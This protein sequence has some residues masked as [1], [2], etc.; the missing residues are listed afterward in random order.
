MSLPLLQERDRAFMQ[1]QQLACPV[2]GSSTSFQLVDE[3]GNGQPYAGLAYQLID[4]EDII[5]SGT[6]DETGSG[7]VLNHYCGVLELRL[8]HAYR[9]KEAPY[10]RLINREHYPL[11]I[12]E[13]QVRAEHTRFINKNAER[14]SFNP[15]HVHA[16]PSA[17]YQVEVRELVEHVAHL[18]PLAPRTFAPLHHLTAL[19]RPLPVKGRIGYKPEL[20]KRFGIPLLPNKH[21]VLEV[22][23]LRALLP[24]MSTHHDFCALNLYQ[25][26]LMATLSYAPFGQDP[27]EHPVLSKTVTFPLQP[28]SG[29]WFGDALAKADE[30]WR[31]D[32]GQKNDLAHYP[33]YEDVAYSKRLEVLPFDPD[34]YPINAPELG[35]A[36]ETPALLHHLDDRHR[37]GSTDSQAF[38]THN[39]ERVLIAVRGTSELPWDL[40]T[41]IDARQV[42]F[43]EGTGQAHQGFYGAAKVA[44]DFATHY[45]DKFHNGQTLIITGHSL[46]GAIALLLAEML[47][48]RDGFVYDILLYTYGA[49]RAADQT[50]IDGA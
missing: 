30:I 26:A 34:L 15:A 4:Y 39:H 35:D 45:L 33:L 44:Y 13:L 50:F 1:D 11:P 32:A 18:P 31:V 8:N 6:L 5:Y 20:A 47:R 37:A 42:P 12:T 36:Q 17:F 14:T 22:R 10:E 25:L 38:I 48:R 41:D 2:R 27:D 46:G 24:L 49:P 9:S 19:F 23:P 3:F 16:A 7:K 29:N 28:S 40:L 21:H 43:E